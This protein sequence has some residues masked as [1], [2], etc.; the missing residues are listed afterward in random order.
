[1]HKRI[2]LDSD[3]EEIAV[4]WLIHLA[5]MR[6]ERSEEQLAEQMEAARSFFIKCMDVL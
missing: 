5:L 1:M 3:S 4:A 6:K 2:A